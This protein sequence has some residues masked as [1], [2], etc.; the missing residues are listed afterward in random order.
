MENTKPQT[1]YLASVIDCRCPRCRQGKLFKNPLSIRV[2]KSMQMNK[3]CP[4]C[5]QATE[6]EI[7]FYYG[8]GYVSFTYQRYLFSVM[9]GYCWLFVYRQSLF[10]L[11]YFQYSSSF[12]T[13]TMAY[14][15]LPQ[16]VDFVVCTL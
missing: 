11:D 12:G 1:S 3:H 13:T 5:G 2:R 15:L 4:L 8:T 14:A 6:I 7:G 9:V 10:L 16:F